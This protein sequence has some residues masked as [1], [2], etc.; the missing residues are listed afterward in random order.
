MRGL[1]ELERTARGNYVKS[2]LTIISYDIVSRPSHS[3]AVI[4]ERQVRFE[5]IRLLRENAHN[6]LICIGEKCYLANHF[7][8]LVQEGTIKFFKKWV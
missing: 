3:K 2:P 4:D 7:D 6:N 1:A 8:K 5:D